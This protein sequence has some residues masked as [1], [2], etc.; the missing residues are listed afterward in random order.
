MYKISGR[1]HGYTEILSNANEFPY[2][3]EQYMVDT[4]L[5]KVMFRGL[6]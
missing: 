1:I 5:K 2:M 3:D 6:L 4:Q